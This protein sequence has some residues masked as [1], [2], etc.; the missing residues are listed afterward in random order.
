MNA[1]TPQGTVYPVLPLRDIVVFPG[2]IVPLFVGREKSVKALEEVMKDDKQ[3]LLIAQ[4]NATQDDP[5]PEDIY[6][7]GTLGTVLQLLKLPDD[8]VKVLV[9]GGKRVRIGGYT[10]KAEFF[11]AR[12]V[13]M[14]EAA[15]DPAELQAASRTVVSEFENY[16]KL[17]KKVP[18]EVVV[19]INKIEEPSKLADTISAHLALKVA[20]KQQLLELELGLEAARA[21]PRPDGRRDRRVAGREE[22][23]QPREA[24]DGEDAARVLSERADEGDPEGAWRDRGRSRRD[25]RDGE[26]HQ[27]D[28]AQQGSAR[29]GQRRAEEAAHDEPDVGRGDGGA[30]LPRMAAVDSVAQADQDHQGPEVRR[31]R[32]Q[33][34]SPWPGEGEGA[35]PRVPRRPAAGRQDEG[36]DPVPGRT[37]GRRQD[38]ARQVDRQGDR[39]QLRAHV[40]RRRARRG[41]DPRPPPDLYRLAAGQGHPEHEE[42]EVVEPALPAGRDRQARRGFP[43]RSVVGAA[44]GARSRAEQRLQ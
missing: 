44:R 34:R 14:E 40:A 42:G 33:R 12:A 39:P 20:D 15:G 31:R 16:V 35:H 1:P 26:A 17:N 32:A 23:P 22:D 13:E 10:D 24:S 25:F 3:I 4:K 29:E 41:R 36:P 38:L 18:P 2:M 27:E 28:Q 30:Q 37:A 5:G 19:S 43:R 8:T 7:I 21:H 6:N 11:E 9:E